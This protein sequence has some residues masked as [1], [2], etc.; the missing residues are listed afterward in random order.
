MLG[1]FRSLRWMPL[2][3][4]LLDYENTQFLLIGHSS[5][6]LD[7]A[8]GQQPGDDKNDKHTPLEEMENLMHEDELR[9]QHL[10]GMY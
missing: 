1:E 2:Q 5:S 6:S 9:V 3:P 7:K 4:K 8:T 10:N